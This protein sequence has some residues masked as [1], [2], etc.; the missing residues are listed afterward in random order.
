MPILTP[1][2][3]P[4]CSDE[5]MERLKEI[6]ARY[7]LPMQSHLSENRGEISWVRGALPMV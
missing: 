1:R 6:Q 4:T 3:I 7:D 2:F 5:L